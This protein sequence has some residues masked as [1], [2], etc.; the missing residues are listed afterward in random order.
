MHILERFGT[1]SLP[2]NLPRLPVG[3][4]MTRDTLLALPGGHW[5]DSQGTEQAPRDNR[6]IDYECRFYDTS[7]TAVETTF[8]ALKALR[9]TRDRL[10][11]R[12]SDDSIQWAHVR[13][14]QVS[15]MRESENQLW[16]E[17]T[18]SFLILS[19]TWNGQHHGDGWDFD[20]GEYFDTGLD[21]DE[22]TG[23]TFVLNSSPK[24]CTINNAGNASLRNLI[25]TLTAGST[26]IT[27]LTV[28]R[29]LAAVVVEGLG[30]SGTIVAGTSLV[31][32][33]GARS[34][35]NDGVDAYDDFNL[36]GSHTT[37]EWITV[38]P[39]DVGIR[40]TRTGGSSDSEVVFDFND[41]YE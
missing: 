7:A 23:D 20:D 24:K 18:L 34:V 32:D 17:I 5:F 25:I 14:M 36:G 16:L 40:F 28:Q 37:E 19:R 39:G 4:A 27:A 11:R 10:Y 31:I 3:T 30:F 38:P 2:S 26:D 41:A 15:S 35:V 12:L 21:L 13:L 22:D 33:C 29:L 9:G 8:N 6:M 1:T